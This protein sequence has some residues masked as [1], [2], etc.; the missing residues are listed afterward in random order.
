MHKLVLYFFS[1]LIQKRCR[2]L[3]FNVFSF[4]VI[5]KQH[6]QKYSDSHHLIQISYILVKWLLPT[7]EQDTHLL[8][9]RYTL[10]IQKLF[11]FK[12]IIVNNQQY[13]SSFIQNLPVRNLFLNGTAVRQQAVALNS[14]EP[15]LV[16]YDLDEL[17]N[18]HTNLANVNES[19]E[20][21]GHVSQEWS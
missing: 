11:N 6:V 14:H 17:G 20:S 9:I 16:T 15:Y 8:E 19:L 13:Q 5:V 4:F 18:T 10:L 7:A 2:M 12:Y 21:C 3:L 1:F